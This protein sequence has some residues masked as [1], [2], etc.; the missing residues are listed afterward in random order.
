MLLSNQIF[1]LK[2]TWS[3]M[4]GDGNGYGIG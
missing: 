1:E 2:I 4:G 3:R